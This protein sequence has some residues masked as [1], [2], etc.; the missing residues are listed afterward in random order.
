[1]IYKLLAA[2]TSVAALASCGKSP[3]TDEANLAPIPNKPHSLSLDGYYAT[4]N[5]QMAKSMGFTE[6]KAGYGD[7]LECTKPNATLLGTPAAATIN[8]TGLKS[9]AGDISK[10]TYEGIEF[11]MPAMTID[12]ACQK[13]ISKG[14]KHDQWSDIASDE[15]I[16]K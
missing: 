2:L 12:E 7:V 13:R 14:S 10:L 3:E 11:K 4:G 16:R 1:M 6:C 9:S 5:G 15:C 8:L